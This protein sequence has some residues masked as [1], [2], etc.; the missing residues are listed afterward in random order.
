MVICLGETAK[1][2]LV[3]HLSIDCDDNVVEMRTL[4]VK[5]VTEIKDTVI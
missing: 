1:V 5:I 3:D 4:N 2:G